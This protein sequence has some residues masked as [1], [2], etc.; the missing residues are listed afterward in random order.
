MLPASASAVIEEKMLD[1]FNLGWIDFEDE[2]NERMGGTTGY[3][4]ALDEL[5]RRAT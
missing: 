4:A 1:G 3:R 5:V 2:A